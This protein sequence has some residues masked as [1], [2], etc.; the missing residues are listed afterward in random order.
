MLA[1]D[2]ATEEE[3]EMLREKEM[4]AEIL[5]VQHEA[6]TFVEGWGGII[7][8][9]ASEMVNS[10]KIQAVFEGVPKMRAEIREFDPR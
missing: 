1:R 8:N 7:F 5:E 9:T 6:N 3:R 2:I 10:K 4:E